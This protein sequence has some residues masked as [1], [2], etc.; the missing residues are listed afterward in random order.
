M[1][2]GMHR[3]ELENRF[4]HRVDR[5]PAADPVLFAVLPGDH[6]Q[7]GPSVDVFGKFLHDFFKTLET[8]L[9]SVLV[10]GTFLVERLD[11]IEIKLLVTADFG[12]AL[13]GFADE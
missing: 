10:T 12:S 8:L 1:G 9:P 6:G 4:N 13:A 7:P 2:P 11:R 5:L 3:L